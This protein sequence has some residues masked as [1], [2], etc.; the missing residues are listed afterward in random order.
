MSPLTV[1][2]LRFYLFN[3][4]IDNSD[5]QTLRVDLWDGAAWNDSIYYWG[6]TD[7][8]PDWVEVMIV[9]SPYNITGD[10]QIRFVVDKSA[11]SP[12]YDDLII[13][14]VNVE[15]APTCPAP[16]AL[17]AT[18]IAATTADLTWTSFSGLSDIE[19]GLG[20][21][22]PTGVPTYTG[23]VSP[24]TVT[25]LTSVTDY[26][27]YVRDDCGAGDY[28]LWTGPYTFTTQP[29]CPQP[30]DLGAENITMTSADLIWVSFSGLSD[31]E[32]GPSGFTPTGVPT[33][34]GV[35]SPYNV[36]GLN[37][38]SPY[39]FYV[40]DDCGGGDFSEWSGPYTL[41]T[42]PGS[43]NL[44]VFEDFEDG[45]V[46]FNNA[47]G[48]TVDW[49]INNTYY[50]SG[51][52]CAHNASENTNTN[53]LHET[54]VI[55][56]SGASI[57]WLDFWQIT[58][59]EGDYDHGYVEISTD[60][61]ATYTPLLA[62]SY[63]GMGI[64]EPPLYNNPEGPCFDEDSYG[65]WGTGSE[66]PDNATWWQH[67]TFDLSNYLTTNVRI[68]FRV[69]TDGS[70]TKFGWLVDEI[71]IYEPAYGTLSGTVTNAANSNPIED[72]VISLGSFTTTSEADGTYE[73]PGITCRKLYCL[74]YQSRIQHHD[75]SRNHP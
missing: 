28:S 2:Q 6:P 71:W 59:L 58:K 17:G 66:I 69:Q 24:F 74:L 10:I 75:C 16:A 40:R 5:W 46:Y 19:L 3:N 15:E 8:N 7:N 37:S 70:V 1:P 48:N 30:F 34:P 62:E 52:Q 27:F 21:F 61:G 63:T 68:R 67:E 54:G 12:Y 35:T 45:F 14:D 44:P 50:H 23:V 55:D 60:A 72:A 41:L 64:Y 32:F 73:I 20:G 43:Q 33:D 56:L 29:S 11:G 53:I 22:T 4:N 26:S 31:V 49:T 57:V 25:G 51:V 47:A 18:Y 65:I 36:D 39:D 42:L 38:A 13:D 9:L